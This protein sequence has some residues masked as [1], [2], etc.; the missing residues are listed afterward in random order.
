MV[1]LLEVKYSGWQKLIGSLVEIINGKQEDLIET[2][3]KILAR[4]CDLVSSAGP[5][6][7]RRKMG[8]DSESILVSL[9]MCLETEYNNKDLTI[10]ALKSLRMAAEFMSDFLGEKP[11]RDY[12]MKLLIQHLAKKDE[13]IVCLTYQ[14]LIDL[15]KGLYPYLADYLPEIIDLSVKHNASK[16]PHVVILVCEFWS[17]LATEETYRKKNLDVESPK[18]REASTTTVKARTTCSATTLPSCLRY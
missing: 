12:M 10:N 1:Y 13:E 2:S 15:V 14:I 16:V 17:A 8:K 6:F 9:L 11:F 7:D 4:I 3:L 5:A 18:R